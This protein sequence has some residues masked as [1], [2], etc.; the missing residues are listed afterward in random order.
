MIRRQD[1][2][3]QSNS[4]GSGKACRLQQIEGGQNDYKLCQLVFVKRGP[5]PRRKE[6]S[7]KL[8]SCIADKS[9]QFLGFCV[10]RW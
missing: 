10:E 3:V 2:L 1:D 6:I 4:G 9:L 7:K 5:T 8:E